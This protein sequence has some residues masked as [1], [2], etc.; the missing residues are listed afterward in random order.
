MLMLLFSLTEYFI[1][2]YSFVIKIWFINISYC[3]IFIQVCH[4][5]LS[6]FKFSIFFHF[7]FTFS[8]ITSYLSV[9]LIK[10]Y[11]LLSFLIVYKQLYSFS[12]AH[13]PLLFV[14]IGSYLLLFIYLL[15]TADYYCL[16]FVGVRYC[17]PIFHY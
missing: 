9:L 2:Y 3:V 17:P 6:L 1:V 10:V 12:I 4:R 16:L 8:S 15:I 14:I 7:F 13:Y 5:S 11:N